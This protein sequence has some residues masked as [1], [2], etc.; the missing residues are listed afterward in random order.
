MSSP[1]IDAGALTGEG[2]D[3]MAELVRE[4]ATAAE[5]ERLGQAFDVGKLVMFGRFRNWLLRQ[6][7]LDDL[8]FD[9]L[10]YG[11]IC[12]ALVSA[13]DDVGPDPNPL[14][15]FIDGVRMDAE[16]DVRDLVEWRRETGMKTCMEGVAGVARGTFKPWLG[17]PAWERILAEK[18]RTGRN[19]CAI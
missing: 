4:S 16:Q 8:K 11:E 14:A 2:K 18:N 6:A 7:E 19:A 15:A 5:A 17:T 9:E 12:K 3:R 10:E 1:K 13:M